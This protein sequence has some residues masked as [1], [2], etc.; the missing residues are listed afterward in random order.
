MVTHRVDRQ[1]T[2]LID[3]DRL[4]SEC[5]RWLP[6]WPFVE[7]E[8]AYWGPPRDDEAAIGE[9]RRQV[10]RGAKQVIIVKPAYWWLDH[11]AGF[12]RYLKDHCRATETNDWMVAYDLADQS[13]K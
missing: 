13:Q 5:P 12:V 3:E 8:G 1:P 10:A 11:Y 2:I 4:R 7:R 6:L 9:L